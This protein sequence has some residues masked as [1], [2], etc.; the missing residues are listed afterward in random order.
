MASTNLNMH[1]EQ[2]LLNSLWKDDPKAYKEIYAKV[3][4][5][6]RAYITSNSGTPDDARDMMQELF[7]LLAKKGQDPNFVLTAKIS[8][9]LYP[10]CENQWLKNLRKAENDQ[11]RIKKLPEQDI[12][13]HPDFENMEDDKNPRVECAEKALQAL[14]EEDRKIL[15]WKHLENKK[16]EEIAEILSISV[17]YSRI[18]LTRCMN[19]IRKMTDACIQSL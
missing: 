12:L 4:P 14:D 6:V 10:V 19:R 13:E 7:F 18:V 11:K 16:H 9:Y 5:M 8:T 2:E 3:F 1:S 15:F 17:G